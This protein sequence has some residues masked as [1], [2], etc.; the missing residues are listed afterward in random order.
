MIDVEPE[1][2]HADRVQNF[3]PVRNAALLRKK[4]ATT[5]SPWMEATLVQAVLALKR[6]LHETIPTVSFPIG[7]MILHPL[8][9]RAFPTNVPTDLLAFD[10]LVLLYFLLLGS[11]NIS[12]RI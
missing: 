9:R 10:P 7:E 1:L 3:T 4:H 11:N 5:Y 6:F 12:E 2:E 8:P